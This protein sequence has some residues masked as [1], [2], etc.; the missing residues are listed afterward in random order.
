MTYSDFLE[1]DMNKRSEKTHAHNLKRLAKRRGLY[2]L[3][4]AGC[5]ETEKEKDGKAKRVQANR[6]TTRP[7]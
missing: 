7:R 3:H 6:F 1:R 2:A 5:S 4:R